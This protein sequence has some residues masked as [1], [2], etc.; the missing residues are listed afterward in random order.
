MKLLS[1]AVVTI[2]AASSVVGNAKTIQATSATLSKAFASAVGG[3]TIVLSGTF[4]WTKTKNYSYSS[5]VTVNAS[6]ATFT[7]S[8]SIENVSNVSVVG[9]TFGSA[10]APTRLGKAISVYGGS[11]LSFT[12]GTYLGAPG[13]G[14]VSAVNTTGLTVSNNSFK[15][16]TVGGGFENVTGLT[17]SNNAVTGAKKDGFNIVGSHNV[18]ASHNSCTAN[19]PSPGAHPDCIQLWS[20]AGKKP[21]S[22]IKILDNYASGATQG[23]TLFTGQLGGADR[24]TISGNVVMSTMSQGVACYNC[25]NSSITNNLLVTLKAAPHWTNLNIVGGSNNIK[26]GNI[27]TRTGVVSPYHP[28]LG[29]L[30]YGAGVLPVNQNASK[31]FNANTVRSG[32]FAATGLSTNA[33]DTRAFN[34]DGTVSAVPDAPVWITMIS[35]FGLLGSAMRLRRRASQIGTL[36]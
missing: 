36:C 23:F 16:L 10:T 4:G 3:D 35:G 32:T 19:S 22:D 8:W 15:N 13:G 26:S 11:N 31:S 30:G 24:V 7:N 12:N 5:K 28:A 17:L 29:Q 27:L 33:L 2:A 21:M 18:V 9:G 1:I 6:A 20:I 34:A 25:R 14:G